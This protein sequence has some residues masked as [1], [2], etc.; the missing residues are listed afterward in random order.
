[1]TTQEMIEFL[2]TMPPEC[3]VLLAYP[4]IDGKVAYSDPHAVVEVS[5]ADPRPLLISFATLEAVAMLYGQYRPE[6]A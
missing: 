3:C 1:M 6:V 4:S 5:E 2:N